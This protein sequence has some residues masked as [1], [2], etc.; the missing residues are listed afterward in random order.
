MK[1][2]RVELTGAFEFL[3]KEV[4]IGDYA[5]YERGQQLGLFLE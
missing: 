3:F 2:K 5:Q 1:K 4:E